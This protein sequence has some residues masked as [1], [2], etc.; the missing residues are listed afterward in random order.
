ML[1]GLASI[2]GFISRQSPLVSYQTGNNASGLGSLPITKPTGT[3]SGDLLLGVM[4]VSNG[5]GGATWTG[6]TGWTEAIDQGA[7]PS[8]RVAYKTAGGSEGASY[9]FT[10]SLTQAEFGLVL[11]L[12]G[13]TWDVI[14]A[15]VTTLTGNGDLVIS[16]VTSGAGADGGWLLACVASAD[17]GSPTHSTPSGMT[18]I[19]THTDASGRRISV[20][21]QDISAGAT[22]TR[23]TTIGGTA[24]ANG[25]I[26]V[27]LA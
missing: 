12:R 21:M 2:G 11:C 25:G 6:D 1:P 18:L 4:S 24:G 27:G 26:L 10:S 22:G 13:V 15:S 9:S 19:A 20:F 16:G 7:E 5:A 23:T 17:T 3:A 8:L 14:G